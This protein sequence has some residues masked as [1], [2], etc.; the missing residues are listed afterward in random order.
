MYILHYSY[1]DG[2]DGGVVGRDTSAPALFPV[3][4]ASEKTAR[5]WVEKIEKFFADP[6][7]EVDVRED[8]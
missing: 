4:F 7:I 8:A 6:N 3:E 1:V 2:S 5:A